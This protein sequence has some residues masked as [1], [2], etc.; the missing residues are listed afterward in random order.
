MI[1][2][3]VPQGSVLGPLLFTIFINDLSKPISRSIV[4]ISADDTT[5][6]TS[7]GVDLDLPV[8]QQRLQH[9]IIKISDWKAKNR[10]S[11]SAQF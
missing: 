6:S 3:G 7:A 9:D 11:P 8:I 5:L 2:Q 4:N 1:T 10:T